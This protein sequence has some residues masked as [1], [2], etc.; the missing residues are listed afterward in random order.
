[1]LTTLAGLG[2]SVDVSVVPGWHIDS[3]FLGQ[4]LFVDYRHIEEAFLPYFPAQDDVRRKG[5]RGPVRCIPT[6]SFRFG[7]GR[8]LQR[9]VM[10]TLRI[11]RRDLRQPSAKPPQ[12]AGGNVYDR[13]I[14]NGGSE[15]NNGRNVTLKS[16]LAPARRISDLSQL[17][18]WEAKLVL[19]DIRRQALRCGWDEVPVVM[20]NHTKSIGDFE[21]IRRFAEFIAAAKDIRV[22]TLRDV[23]DN[24]AAGRYPL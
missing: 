19:K 24:L 18:F 10:S 6:Q 21:P 5:P 9:R 12:G 7:L 2:I 1:L 17:S 23:C 8:R 16:L 22:V 14:P 11:C 4:R 13:R 3:S 20:T 15:K